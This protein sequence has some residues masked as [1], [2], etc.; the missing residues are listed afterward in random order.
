MG[1]KL[2]V[3]PGGAGMER[4][5]HLTRAMVNVPLD[6]TQFG[7]VMVELMKAP[8]SPGAVADLLQPFLKQF[9]LEDDDQFDIRI[10]HEAVNYAAQSFRIFWQTQLPNLSHHDYRFSRWLG[11]DL[12]LERV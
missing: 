2:V 5:Q 1:P 9:R 12:V 7:Q 8:D 4:V 11:T 3:L 10:M 6:F